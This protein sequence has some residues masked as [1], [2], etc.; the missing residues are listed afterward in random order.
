M[1]P[2]L[3][4]TRIN[5]C[6][7]KS[8]E[9]EADPWILIKKCRYSLIIIGL[10]IFVYFNSLANNFISDDF[11]QIINNLYIHSLANI[12]AFF[13]G[14]TFYNGGSNINGAYYKPLLTTYFSFIYTF[15][16]PNYSLFHFFQIS[17]HIL[18]TYLLFVLLKHFFKKLLALLLSLIFLVHPI[19]S[20]AVFYISAMQE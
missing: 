13:T 9:T 15:F 12:S 10:G 1:N 20:E 5:L 3:L 19:N 17:L 11:P 14:S 16:G 4:S 6:Y 2:I 8:M 7:H 18:N